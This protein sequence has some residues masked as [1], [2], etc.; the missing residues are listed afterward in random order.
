MNYS[1]FVGLDVG[2]KS[3]DACL[4]SL[5]QELSH[6]TFP[7]TPE[8]IEEL[9]HWIKQHGVEVETALF[10]AENMGSYV[11]DLCLS[12]YQYHFPLALECPLTIKKSIGLQRGKNDRI[13]ARRIAQYASLHY[14]KLRLY[15]LPDKDLVRL[16]N[17]MVIRD[18]LVKQ[19][20][21]S[22]K[23]LELTRETSGLADLMTA[24]TFLE[25][26][27][28]LVKEKISY[29]EQE[30]EKII[31]SNIALLTNYQLLTSIKGIGPINAIV[32]LCVT[33]NFHRFSDPRK[34][35]C[36]SGVAPFE[37]SSGTS[38]RGKTKTSHL[39]NREVKVYLT[40]A[41]I[42]AIAWDPQI[43]AY[44]KRKI[45]EGKHKASVINAVRAKIIARCFAVIKRKTPFVTL[46]A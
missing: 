33:G 3:F 24:M 27:I 13:D 19:K 21:S 8:G 45:A 32:L 22:L 20:V 17:W 7:N 43:K 5:D 41:A 39:A 35:A 37:Y 46:R 36:Y 9:L 31:S 44:Y 10:C 11:I 18:N 1:H 6:H 29:V 34:F 14:R 2:K 25:K 40:R 15:E 23:L 30:M 38:I 12:S 26:Q 16:R 42:T 28:S 4:M